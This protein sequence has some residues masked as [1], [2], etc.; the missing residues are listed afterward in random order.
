MSRGMRDETR[1]RTNVEEA[2]KRG[3]TRLRQAA[4]ADK[5]PPI[6]KRHQNH[7]I[8]QR[9][10]DLNDVAVQHV[11]T[12]I[13]GIEDFK[14]VRGST[15]VLNLTTSTEFAHLLTDAAMISRGNVLIADLYQ[16][17]RA[18]VF[19]DDDDAEQEG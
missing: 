15:A 13:A 2:A 16:V 17:S 9:E 14:I 12:L 18:Y 7:L 5:H 19:G 6:P 8:P 11:G 4:V 10:I 3:R 1:R